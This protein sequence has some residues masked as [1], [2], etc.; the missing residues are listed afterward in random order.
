M[1]IVFVCVYKIRGGFKNILLF[2]KKVTVENLEKNYKILNYK[3]VSFWFL[4]FVIVLLPTLTPLKL[5]WIVAERYSY[6]GMLGFCAIFAYFFY[7]L[8]NAENVKIAILGI[9]I[10][11][12]LALGIRTA[13]RNLDWFNE[14]T[15][16]FA[17]VK[18]SP[19]SPNIH[20]NLGDVYARRGQHDK[21]IEEFKYAIEL[22]P[23][24][25]DAIHN[26]A[27]TY[28]TFYQKEQDESKKI[29]YLA[30]AKQYY[31]EAVT[32]NPNLWQSHQNLGTIYF[33]EGNLEAGYREYGIALEINA[34]PGLISNYVYIN[35]QLK[36]YNEAEKGVQVLLEQDP[37]NAEL[38]GTLRRIRDLK[39]EQ[40][41]IPNE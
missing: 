2:W 14:D 9:F 36:N 32:H 23:N 5:S 6:L 12:L 27:Y 31:L 35:M 20:N 39:S 33:S 13:Y 15:L 30:L 38:Q 10:F 21:A 37:T 24:Y 29:E 40:T 22:K 1:T 19:S 41:T 4:F 11:I 7:K 34:N 28:Q 16:W 26:L 8:S 3:F 17:T 25:A 18:Y